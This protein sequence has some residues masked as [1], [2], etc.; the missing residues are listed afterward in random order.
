MPIVAGC[1]FEVEGIEG[2][3][4]SGKHLDSDDRWEIRMKQWFSI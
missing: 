3:D 1:I 4:G 2:T